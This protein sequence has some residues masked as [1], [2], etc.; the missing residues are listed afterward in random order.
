MDKTNDDDDNDD[1]IHAQL[2]W[3]IP[4]R[5][6]FTI[7]L[8]QP[9]F[10]RLCFRAI[11]FIATLIWWMTLEAAIIQ[12]KT[13]Q[14]LSPCLDTSHTSP[15]IRDLPCEFY[16]STYLYLVLNYVSLHKLNKS[17]PITSFQVIISLSLFLV[18]CAC[19]L[20]YFCSWAVS[21]L[22]YQYTNHL[23]DILLFD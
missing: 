2:W 3:L 20:I 1:T 9:S 15:S 11:K 5:L 6:T 16:F 18:H 19:N 17:I 12:H 13:F 4:M 10:H 21:G 8:N 7:G 14:S 22:H 23:K